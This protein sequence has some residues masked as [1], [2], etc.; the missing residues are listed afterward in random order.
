MTRFENWLW[1]SK[2][3]FK[4]QIA[5]FQYSNPN[6]KWKLTQHVLINGIYKLLVGCFMPVVHTALIQAG[7]GRLLY[8]HTIDPGRGTGRHGSYRAPVIC[9]ND[10]SV[11]SGHVPVYPTKLSLDHSSQPFLQLFLI[12]AM[13]YRWAVPSVKPRT[14]SKK[15]HGVTLIPVDQ[16]Q[17]VSNQV[18]HRKRQDVVLLGKWSSIILN[19]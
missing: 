11:A 5:L 7:P 15:L 4:F 13:L 1:N 12:P 8:H 14:A 6:C 19:Y 16:Y 10:K 3:C 2:S 18:L 17:Y 9:I